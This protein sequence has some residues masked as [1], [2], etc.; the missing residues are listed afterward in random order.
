MFVLNIFKLFS[1]CLWNPIYVTYH[2]TFIFDPYVSY[3][4]SN[5][6][7]KS[8]TFHVFTLCLYCSMILIMCS[9]AA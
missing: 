6:A 1:V 7:L 3:F 9:Y 8:S 2:I 4:L 5:I